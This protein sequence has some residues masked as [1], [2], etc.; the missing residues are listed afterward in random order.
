MWQQIIT[1]WLVNPTASSWAL[2]E[3]V[4]QKATRREHVI[5]VL[6]LC[7]CTANDLGAHQH[8]W[9]PECLT[10][11]QPSLRWLYR[12]A[13]FAFVF[14]RSELTGDTSLVV[15]LHFNP[16]VF[17]H[18]RI[19]NSRAQATEHKLQSLKI[20]VFSSCAFTV[21]AGELH[22]GPPVVVTFSTGDL[23]VHT[24]ELEAK[25][26]SRDGMS[27]CTRLGCSPQRIS[28]Q[29]NRCGPLSSATSVV[30]DLEQDAL[31]LCA[32]LFLSLK[33]W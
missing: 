17:I 33:E 32:S 8:I 18:R 29:R 31:L 2:K 6:P 7:I 28:A 10:V 25:A 14:P 11:S 13:N 23:A 27:T 30:C 22:D 16:R 3:G 21:K 24:T 15:L 4:L 26:W 1:Q 5:N 9:T 19:L 20:W 12:N